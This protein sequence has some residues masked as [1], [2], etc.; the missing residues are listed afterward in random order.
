MQHS[1]K[2]G[3]SFGLASGV[4]TTIGLMVGLNAGTASKMVVLGGILTIAIADSMSD[5]MGIHMSEESENKHTTKEI[6]TSTVTT[7]LAK[8]IIALTFA[9]PVLIFELQTAII[10]SVI[11]GLSLVIVSTYFAAKKQK[12]GILGP[13][14]EHFIVVILVI[15][16]TNFVG[17]TIADL[18]SS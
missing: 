15:L 2:V 1:I 16:A 5:A 11:W 18:F 14:A 13:I 9:V 8:L 4:I 17:T 3:L 10:V 7:F 6:W 12:T